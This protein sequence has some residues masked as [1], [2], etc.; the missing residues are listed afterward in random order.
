[1]PRQKVIFFCNTGEVSET[2]IT[3][4]SLCNAPFYYRMVTGD[5]VM[6]VQVSHDFIDTYDAATIMVMQ[7]LNVWQKHVLKKPILILTL[8]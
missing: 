1:M 8:L 4:E 2:G 3:P 5:F 6:R 7:D